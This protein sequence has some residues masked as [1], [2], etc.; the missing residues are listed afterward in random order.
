M[1]DIRHTNTILRHIVSSH[2]CF[3][4]LISNNFLERFLERA[5]VEPFVLFAK[6][7]R[8]RKVNQTGSVALFLPRP[9][10]FCR[11][12]KLLLSS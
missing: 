2:I 7:K 10:S 1:K 12:S 3:V 9:L 4:T 11:L 8:K 6:K 5:N